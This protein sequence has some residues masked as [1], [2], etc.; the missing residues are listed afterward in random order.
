[1]E[2]FFLHK[3]VPKTLLRWGVEKYY[4]F[5]LPL[6]FVFSPPNKKESFLQPLKS[7][8]ILLWSSSLT[9]WL[10]NTKCQCRS[11]KS[12]PRCM[13]LT[14]LFHP[15]LSHSP[16]SPSQQVT[17]CQCRAKAL[18]QVWLSSVPALLG[19]TLPLLPRGAAGGDREG[20]HIIPGDSPGCT[21][22]SG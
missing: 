16:L 3:C 19:I 8:G 20:E 21:S 17:H 1:M 14:S 13:T 18:L 10:I 11:V 2:S 22:P 7:V 15:C 6:L 5:P 4:F 9:I 12:L